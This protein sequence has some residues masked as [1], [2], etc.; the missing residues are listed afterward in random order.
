MSLVD[1]V[2]PDGLKP[3]IESNEM[4]KLILC[5]Y[6]KA[7]IHPDIPDSTILA[8]N[9]GLGMLYGH[10]YRNVKTN[11]EDWQKLAMYCDKIRELRIKD[12]D[13]WRSYLKKQLELK[14]GDEK[15]KL[16]NMLNY[17]LFPDKYID[18]SEV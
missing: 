5:D 1:T 10:V 7:I 17:I 14:Q 16:R 3:T 8:Y 4:N 9:I 18:L 12:P 15:E 11:K 13:N 2:K 6:L